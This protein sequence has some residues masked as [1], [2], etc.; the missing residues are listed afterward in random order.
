VRALE[1]LDLLRP[2][3]D[4]GGSP[5]LAPFGKAWEV[6]LGEASDRAREYVADAD[7]EPQTP[8]AKAEEAPA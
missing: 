4:G 3:V 7:T 2:L 6:A 8:V 5:K 1:L